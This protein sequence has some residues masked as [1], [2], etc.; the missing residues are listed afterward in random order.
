MSRRALSAALLCRASS[1]RSGAGT[2]PLSDGL[3]QAARAI[4][5]KAAE[6]RD[7]GCLEGGSSDS[8]HG[9]L[10]QVHRPYGWR[11]P[12]GTASTRSVPAPWA[13]TRAAPGPAPWAGAGGG[14][15][16]QAN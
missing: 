14:R 11:L 13:S 16:W 1:A 4:S 6:L 15:P 9:T 5:A 3:V 12:H 2:G 8:F 10:L 7:M